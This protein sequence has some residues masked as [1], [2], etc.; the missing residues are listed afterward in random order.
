MPQDMGFFFSAA[1]S[2]SS[3]GSNVSGFFSSSHEASLDASR[4]KIEGLIQLDRFLFWGSFIPVVGTSFATCRVVYGSLVVGLALCEV[5]NKVALSTIRSDRP[6]GEQDTEVR[7][8]ALIQA[9]KEGALPTLL[10]G[11]QHI[12]S[13]MIVSGSVLGK[14]SAI[15]WELLVRPKLPQAF[16][17][18]AT[19]DLKACTQLLDRVKKHSLV[20]SVSKAW[21]EFIALVQAKPTPKSA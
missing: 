10:Y 11:I 7:G 6:R 3:L 20:Q 19:V 13:G 2:V 12:G 1:K 9:L 15:A 14:I 16:A 21:N 8:L 5:I 18:S 17:N 4:T